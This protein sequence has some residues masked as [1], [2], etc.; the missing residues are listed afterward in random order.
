MVKCYFP[1]KCS[2]RHLDKHSTYYKIVLGGREFIV[3]VKLLNGV[4]GQ[5]DIAGLWAHCGKYRLSVKA[6]LVYNGRVCWVYWGEY[7]LAF[8]YTCDGEHRCILRR[9]D[10]YRT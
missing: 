3:L 2:Q 5:S 7:N 4:L 1:E 8:G 10:G 6:R 9:P